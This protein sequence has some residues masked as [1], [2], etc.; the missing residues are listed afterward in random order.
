MIDRYKRSVE[1][2]PNDVDAWI[3]LG[4]AYYDEREFHKAIE[5]YKKSLKINPYFCAGFNK[6][7]AY[8]IGAYYQIQPQNQ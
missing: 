4:D 5:C 7:P 8:D 2:D 1:L 3:N 6:R